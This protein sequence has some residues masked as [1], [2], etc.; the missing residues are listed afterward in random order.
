MSAARHRKRDRRMSPGLAPDLRRI[1]DALTPD[2]AFRGAMAK[3]LTEADTPEVR[4]AFRGTGPAHRAGLLLA[5][6]DAAVA[7]AERK[8][9]DLCS[10]VARRVRFVL[11]RPGEDFRG[12]QCPGDENAIVG[13]AVLCDRC[14]GCPPA[15]I[16]RRM[17]DK[18]AE[19]Q[20]KVGPGPYRREAV[21][22]AGVGEVAHLPPRCTLEE[23]SACRRPL[24][25]DAD[26]ILG[27]AE[28]IAVLCRSCAENAAAAGRLDAVAVALTC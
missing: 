24:W 16:K 22:G 7:L 12:V 2:P 5:L 27:R 21:F 28:E 25:V 23:C 9:C 8:P 4:A 18:Y 11:A 1:I 26:A 10:A 17:L 6:R 19:L 15:E 14:A 13:F 3:A 20:A